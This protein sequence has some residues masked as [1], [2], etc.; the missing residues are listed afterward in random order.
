MERTAQ[1]MNHEGTYWV[2]VRQCY[3][4]IKVIIFILEIYNM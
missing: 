1:E 2:H 3:E 4:K